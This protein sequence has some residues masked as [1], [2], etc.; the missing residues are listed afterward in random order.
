MRT[1]RIIS[2]RAIVEFGKTLKAAVQ[3]LDDW[4]RVTKRAD[5]KNLAEVQAMFPHADL[6]G[7]CVVFN[8]G[9]NKFRLITRVFFQTRK[10]Y[11]VLI[12]THKEYDKGGWKS[13]CDC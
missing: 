2:H 7:T 5:W 1:V 8:I 10:V 4:Y 13:D 9:G 6:V 3:P 11:I 12:L